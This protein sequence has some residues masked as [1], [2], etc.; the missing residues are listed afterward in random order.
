MD[1][2]VIKGLSCQ[3]HIGVTAQERANPQELL[4]DIELLLDLEPAAN[5]DDIAMTADYRKL[6]ETIERHIQASRYKLLETVAQAIC[7]LVLEDTQIK[8]V[9]LTV[10]KFPDKLRGKIEYAAVE[11]TR[12]KLTADRWP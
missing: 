10:R 9:H 7:K 11:M 8:S 5:L 6:V 12:G 1:K 4:I 2:I 3:A